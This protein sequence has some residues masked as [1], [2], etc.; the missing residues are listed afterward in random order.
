MSGEERLKEATQSDSIVTPITVLIT[1]CGVRA[2]IAMM[3]IM[4][5]S[6]QM[7]ILGGKLVV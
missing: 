7:E 3:I 5:L 4:A 1:N 2:L 6:T